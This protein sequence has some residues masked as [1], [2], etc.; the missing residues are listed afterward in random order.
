M[1]SI[2]LPVHLKQTF[3]HIL[4][5]FNTGDNWYDCSRT[6][7]FRYLNPIPTKEPENMADVAHKIST[8]IHLC[9]KVGDQKVMTSKPVEVG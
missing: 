1:P 8:W 9:I 7:I 4:W 5:I 6:L 2:V 3:P